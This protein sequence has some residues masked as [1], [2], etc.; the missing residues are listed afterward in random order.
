MGNNVWP[1]V[2]NKETG[3]FQHRVSMENNQSNTENDIS[4]EQILQI[5][6]DAIDAL[7]KCKNKF[8]KMRVLGMMLKQVL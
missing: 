3:K 1:S 4:N 5:Y 6:F 8:D 7:Q 2:S